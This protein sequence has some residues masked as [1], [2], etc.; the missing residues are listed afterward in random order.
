MCPGDATRIFFRVFAS[1]AALS[2]LDFRSFD[3]SAT[4]LHGDID[5]GLRGTTP[6]YG[7]KGSVL[8]RDGTH[9]R[10]GTHVYLLISN[11]IQI[12]M[13]FCSCA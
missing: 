1:I 13:C 11:Y 6:R 9:P 8:E 10:A 5:G 2:D 3:V 12:S 4:H 7:D